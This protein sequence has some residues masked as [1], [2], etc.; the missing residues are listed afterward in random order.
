MPHSALLGKL[1]CLGG[2]VPIIGPLRALSTH[3]G[4]HSINLLKS[5]YLSILLIELARKALYKS[6]D[7]LYLPTKLLCLLHDSFLPN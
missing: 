1:M 5:I 2:S 4:H 6:I 7:I 3:I